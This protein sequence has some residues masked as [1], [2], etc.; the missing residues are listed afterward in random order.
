M[1]SKLFKVL[2]FVSFIFLFVSTSCPPGSKTWVEGY[3]LAYVQSGTSNVKVRWE[4]NNTWHDG[5]IETTISAHHGVCVSTD[6]GLLSLL[7]CRKRVGL[8]SSTLSLTMGLG[9]GYYDEPREY[10]ISILSAPSLAYVGNSD[11]LITYRTT[12]DKIVLRAIGSNLRLLQVNLAPIDAYFKN[13]HV[14]DQPSIAYLNGKLLLAWK[15]RVGDTYG[16]RIAVGNYSPGDA[17]IGWIHYGDFPVTETNYSYF[18]DTQYSPAITQEGSKFY[19]GIIRGT[20]RPPDYEGSFLSRDDL[21]IYTSTD[22]INWSFTAKKVGV[23]L[24]GSLSIAA[25]PDGSII[26]VIV[27]PDKKQVLKYNGSWSELNADSV[28]NGTPKW[29]PFSIA[30]SRY[31]R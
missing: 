1:F 11:W 26:A 13:D 7:A 21:F 9:A 17:E 2:V 23:I 25:R 15:R 22:G 4:E 30:R 24:R 14:R 3:Y 10:T 8:F 6:N 12:G 5:N 19:F 18:N 28:F 20:R 16:L 29:V 31:L 27:S